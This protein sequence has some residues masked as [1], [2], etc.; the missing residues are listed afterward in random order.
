MSKHCKNSY[1][2]PIEATIDLIGGK[3]KSVILWHLMV[4]LYDTVNYIN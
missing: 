4:K 3:Y 1:N 2:C